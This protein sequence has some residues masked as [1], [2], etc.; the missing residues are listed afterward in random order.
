[1]ANVLPAYHQSEKLLMLGRLLKQPNKIRRRMLDRVSAG[2][3]MLPV[4]YERIQHLAHP[5]L[6]QGE[7][8]L[9][10]LVERRAM[11]HGPF[12]QVCDANLFNGA[13]G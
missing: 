10:V 12:A 2:G 8:I 3:G 13:L 4:S 1:L 11:Y 5:S 7:L 9:I 6:Q